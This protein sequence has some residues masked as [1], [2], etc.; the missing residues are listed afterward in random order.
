[1]AK[2]ILEFDKWDKKKIAVFHMKRSPHDLPDSLDEIGVSYSVFEQGPNM[3]K[4]FLKKEKEFSGIII[5]G[6]KLGPN[7]PLPKFP[8][9]ILSINIP[10]MGIC[11]GHEILG[12][13][14]GSKLVDCNGGFKSGIGESSEV[15]MKIYPDEIYKGLDTSEEQIVSKFVGPDA[16]SV[17]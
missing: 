14:L 16:P 11:L 3:E 12:C 9:S 2:R 13:Y 4:E 15:E 10:K 8:K 17:M 1:M 5:G 7:E 6:G